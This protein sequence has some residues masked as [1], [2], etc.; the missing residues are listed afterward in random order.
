MYKYIKT[1]FFRKFPKRFNEVKFY[2][3]Q[4]D[5][6]FSNIDKNTSNEEIKSSKTDL[7]E[8]SNQK[9]SP[10]R[11]KFHVVS[12]LFLRWGP[13]IFICIITFLLIGLCMYHAV[14]PLWLHGHK[15]FILNSWS[16]FTFFFILWMWCY[17][18]LLFNDPGSMENEVKYEPNH[19]CK[20]RCIHCQCYK[21]YRAHH[22]HRCGKCF[23]RLDHH[24]EALGICIGLRNQKIFLLFIFYSILIIVIGCG[25]LFYG[26]LV[27]PYD[28]FPF[29][30]FLDIAMASLI[31]VMLII[32]LCQQIHKIFSGRTTFEYLFNINVPCKPTALENFEVLFGPRSN[33]L[34]WFIPNGTSPTWTSAFAWEKDRPTKDVTE[35]K[36]D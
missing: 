34:D 31:C 26:G 1:S 5:K 3:M 36:R 12:K 28:S 22:C 13:P 14:I 16:I 10:F 20:T 4:D 35:I 7:I 33:L 18:G 29:I 21:P 30:I 24:C 19:T 23:A 27:I 11:K 2:I 9:Q 32:L 8:K 25:I 6:N 15:F 17:F